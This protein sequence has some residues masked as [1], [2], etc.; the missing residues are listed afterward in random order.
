MEMYPPKF[1]ETGDS[2]YLRLSNRE[3]TEPR[4]GMERVSHLFP[5]PP[6]SVTPPENSPRKLGRKLRY[7]LMPGESPKERKNRLA[8]ERKRERR[9][10]KSQ[11]PESSP[12]R[13]VKHSSG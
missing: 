10:A 8:R 11:S 5:N 13:T 4:T 6:G 3:E 1:L 7:P 2:R 12:L 9:L